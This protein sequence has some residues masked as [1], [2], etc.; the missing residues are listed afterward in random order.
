[1][2]VDFPLNGG[3]EKLAF[4]NSFTRD[5]PADP[6]QGNFRRQVPGASRPARPA[7]WSSEARQTG[8]VTSLSSPVAGSCASCRAQRSRIGPQRLGRSA[9]KRGA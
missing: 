4:D 5:L 2:S 1:M 3:L 7:R 6:E 8:R 9:D